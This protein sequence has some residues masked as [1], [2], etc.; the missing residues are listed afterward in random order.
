MRKI[1][2]VITK[3]NWGGAQKY[4]YELATSL[5]KDTFETA[6]ANGGDGELVQRLQAAGIRTIPLSGLGRDIRVLKDASSFWRLW[7]LFRKEKPDVVHLNSSKAGGIGALAARLAGV[8]RVIFTAHGWAFNEDR[9]LYKKIIIA[10]LHWITILLST[11]TIA[12]SEFMKRQGE[13]FPFTKRKLVVIRNGATPIEFLPR[14][15]SREALMKLIPAEKTALIAENSLWIGT[16]SELH[17]NKGLSYALAAVAR[18][19]KESSAPFFF[20]IIGE[21]EERAALETQIKTLGLENTVFLLGHVAEAPRF[22]KAFDLFTLTSTTEA[23]A[24]VLL[25]AG[26][27]GLPVVATNTGGIPEV[28]GGNDC[29]I[30]VHARAEKDIALGIKTLLEDASLRERLGKNLERKIDTQFSFQKMM[31]ETTALY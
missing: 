11:K 14:E 15:E 24:Y 23:L 4:V 1:L 7:R 9:P 25:E 10:G 31:S 8:P 13:R 5:P 27:A 6:V 17:K 20:C 28:I 30:L 19:A 18:V 16:I 2:Y 21:G 29:G 22:L 12:V 26:Q 3:S